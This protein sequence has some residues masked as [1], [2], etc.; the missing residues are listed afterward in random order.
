MKE[1]KLL[2]RVQA[3]LLLHI[4]F[5]LATVQ[6]YDLKSDLACNNYGHLSQQVDLNVSTKSVIV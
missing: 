2:D 4:I 3:V 1:V 5:I 6:E